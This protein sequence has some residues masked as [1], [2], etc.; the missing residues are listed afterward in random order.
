MNLSS[1]I[2]VHVPTVLAALVAGCGGIERLPPPEQSMADGGAG[3]S[4]CGGVDESCCGGETCDDPAQYHELICKQSICRSREWALLPM[5]NPPSTGLPNPQSYT[6]NGELVTDKVT[7]LVWQ[8]ASSPTQMLWQAARDYCRDLALDGGGFHLPTRIELA[9]LL[10]Y[11]KHGDAIDVNAFEVHGKEAVASDYWTSTL[12]IA[13]QNS[14]S[15]SFFAG[16]VEPL[17]ID[18]PSWVRCAR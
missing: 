13:D 10:D 18:R 17:G 11:T 15:V 2:S 16:H 7:G 6:V 1:F 5:P 4:G 12:H 3:G 8:R 9:S 14:W